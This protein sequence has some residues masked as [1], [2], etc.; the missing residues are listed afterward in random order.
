MKLKLG[1]KTIQLNAVQR[2]SRVGHRIARIYLK[3]GETIEV[4]CG[5]SVP[6]EMVCSYPGTVEQLQACIE[7][8]K[9]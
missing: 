3:T 4:I 2:V 9:S 1:S 7:R 6:N 8:L 5:V